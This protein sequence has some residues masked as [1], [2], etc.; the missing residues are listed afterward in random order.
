MTTP[1][2]PAPDGQPSAQTG[3]LIARLEAAERGSRIC[4]SVDDGHERFV[5]IA[6]VRLVH[7][8]GGGFSARGNF[9]SAQADALIRETFFD[10]STRD[11][12]VQVADHDPVQCGCVITSLEYAGEFEG[13]A[14]FAMT[15]R[16]LR[17]TGSP[18]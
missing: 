17:A 8:S 15:V 1:P 12:R 10:Q 18:R 3:E 13:E 6:T 5:P 11:W 14:T 9:R 7:A 2:P 16:I 4:L